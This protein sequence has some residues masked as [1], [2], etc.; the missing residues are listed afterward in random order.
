MKLPNANQA[1]VDLEK[2]RGYC[3]NPAHPRGRHKARV[4][5]A[6]L[7]ITAGET[8]PRLTSCFVL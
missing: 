4:F 8:A 7:G 5:A 3:L 1:V 2:L 6:A